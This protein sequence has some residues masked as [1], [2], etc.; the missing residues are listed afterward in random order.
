MD[1]KSYRK[2]PQIL[3][4]KTGEASEQCSWTRNST[5]YLW[6]Q[7]LEMFDT[8]FHFKYPPDGCFYQCDASFL[9]WGL[10]NSSWKK[11]WCVLIVYFFSRFRFCSVFYVFINI[12]TSTILCIWCRSFFLLMILT[13][14][15]IHTDFSQY[16]HVFL[17]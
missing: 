14:F 16:M 13:L 12:T 1:T 15:V 3:S 2:L 7:P 17:L 11:L 9:E 5:H 6:F 8:S 4:N 10:P